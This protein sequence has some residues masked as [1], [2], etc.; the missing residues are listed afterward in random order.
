MPWQL[1][2]E[3]QQQITII[4]N[5]MEGRIIQLLGASEEPETVLVLSSFAFP[6]ALLPLELLYLVV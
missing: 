4:I 2:K 3:Q 5:P 1:N 6:I